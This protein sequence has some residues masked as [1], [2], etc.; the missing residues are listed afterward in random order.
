[1]SQSGMT[2]L[3][4]VVETARGMARRESARAVIVP[5]ITDGA[6]FSNRYYRD[7][8]AS[9]ATAG[10]ALHAV[11]VGTFPITE[12]QET[13]E[14]AYLLDGGARDSGGQR[15]ALLTAMAIPAALEKLGRELSSQYR[16]VYSRPES[17]I[18]PEKLD[19]A[20]ARPGVTVRAAPLRP[21]TGA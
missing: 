2:L 20:S 11:T 6:E 13:R 17:L 15:V 10:V 21:R 18:P 1:M 7:V 9:L 12:E 14:R 16:V 8:L 3:D 19:V 4:A 5:V